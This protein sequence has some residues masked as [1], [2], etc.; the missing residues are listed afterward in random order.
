MARPDAEPLLAQSATD[1]L[2]SSAW[3]LILDGE[4]YGVARN[5]PAPANHPRRQTGWPPRT[6]GPPSK[7]AASHRA[8]FPAGQHSLLPNPRDRKGSLRP[9]LPG[10]P[11]P[12]RRTLGHPP[13]RPTEKNGRTHHPGGPIQLANSRTLDP[14]AGAGAGP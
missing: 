14:S 1:R 3:E 4:S 2:Q 5:Q 11:W 13:V 6:P 10:T 7:T 12:S 8:T 9:A